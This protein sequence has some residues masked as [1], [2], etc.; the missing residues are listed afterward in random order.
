MTCLKLFYRR[1]E[2]SREEWEFELDSVKNLPALALI[3]AAA[4]KLRLPM[5]KE[6][7]TLQWTTILQVKHQ[8]WTV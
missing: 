8:L 2:E 7:L 6:N 5:N 1:T 3:R 4:I